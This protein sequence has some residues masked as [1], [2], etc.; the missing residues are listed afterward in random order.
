MRYKSIH[1]LYNTG[2]TCCTNCSKCS[3]YCL[4]FVQLEHFIGHLHSS[5]VNQIFPNIADGFSDTIPAMREQ[6]VK[7]RLLT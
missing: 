7:V 4:A 1:V 6:T 2:C 5:T 3:D